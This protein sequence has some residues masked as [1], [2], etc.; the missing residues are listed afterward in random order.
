MP[1][2]QNMGLGA[3]AA[4]HEFGWLFRCSKWKADYESWQSPAQQNVG[5]TCLHFTTWFLEL[6]LLFM[7]GAGNSDA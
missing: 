7:Y 6:A 2:L 3:G 1:S 4:D 5:P